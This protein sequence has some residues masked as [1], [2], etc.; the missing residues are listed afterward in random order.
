MDLR[1]MVA[2]EGRDAAEKV[3]IFHRSWYNRAWVGC[4]M[5]FSSK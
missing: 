5:G 4:E 1:L 2:F 3:V